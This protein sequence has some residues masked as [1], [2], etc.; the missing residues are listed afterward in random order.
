MKPR[1]KHLR[2]RPLLEPLEPRTFFD[3]LPS[4]T[5]TLSLSTPITSANQPI[6]LTATVTSSDLSTP[7]G[8]VAFLE[9][10]NTSLD[11]YPFLHPADYANTVTYFNPDTQ[12]TESAELLGTAPLSPDGTA[13]L[14]LSSFPSSTAA[15]TGQFRAVYLGSSPLLSLGDRS[16]T[17]ASPGQTLGPDPAPATNSSSSF[18]LFPNNLPL[19]L[20]NAQLTVLSSLPDNS[21]PHDSSLAQSFT[22]KYG[23]DFPHSLQMDE[24]PS[25]PFLLSPSPT[26][27][28]I[29]ISVSHLVSVQNNNIYVITNNEFPYPNLY[30]YTATFTPAPLFS[31]AEDSNSAYQSSLSSIGTP[32]PDQPTTLQFHSSHTYTYT[33]PPSYTVSILS[34]LTNER[35]SR[36]APAYPST[37]SIQSATAGLIVQTGGTYSGAGSITING[38]PH[39]PPFQPSAPTPT[40]TVSFFD[41]DTLLATVPLDSNGNASFTPDPRSLSLGSHSIH[42]SYSGDSLYLPAD[43]SPDTFTLTHTSTHISL[44]NLSYTPGQPLPLAATISTSTPDTISPTGTASFFIDGVYITPVTLGTSARITDNDLTL[45]PGDHTFAVSYSGDD[46]CLPSSLTATLTLSPDG[47]AYFSNLTP[48]STPIPTDGLTPYQPVYSTAT[49]IDPT[50]PNWYPI[51]D[52]IPTDDRPV[53]GTIENIVP[54]LLAPP[55]P[56]PSDPSSPSQPITTH[57]APLVKASLTP[58]H[59]TLPPKSSTSLTLTLKNTSK[60]LPIHRKYTITYYLSTDRTFSSNDTRFS[61][62]TLTATL[63]KNQSQSY[64]LTYKLPSKILGTRYLIAIATTPTGNLQIISKT[65]LHIT[66]PAKSAK[67]TPHQ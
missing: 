46:D 57:P 67:Q 41:G 29:T 60:A 21:T 8:T 36:T 30:S 34:S 53:T 63:A 64:T 37:G 59:T 14:S 50:D 6:T 1:P 54:P 24:Y 31:H 17:Y 10:I 12:L 48:S 23:N 18:L 51:T 42:A 58:S 35:L 32:A 40:G 2:R 20:N 56:T 62:Q 61:K 39:S 43:S 55:N 26:P 22:D 47:H 7:T 3:A 11:P 15:F 28:I 27:L 66:S 4:T 16:I 38:G 49:P 33:N 5:T 65:P 25:D 9:P 13:S 45:S 52:P 44:P 19:S